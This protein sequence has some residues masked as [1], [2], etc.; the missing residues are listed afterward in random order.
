MVIPPAIES[1]VPI[2]TTESQ[3]DG[4]RFPVD[5]ASDSCVPTTPADSERGE[6]A[7]PLVD[8]DVEERDREPFE[9]PV[10]ESDDDLEFGDDAMVCHGEPGCWEINLVDGPE[11]DCDSGK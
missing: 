9:I 4:E 6:N 5:V 2:S 7:V 8:A 10:P 1:M 11:V 3:P